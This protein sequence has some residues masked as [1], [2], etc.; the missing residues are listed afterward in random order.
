MKTITLIRHAKSSWEFNLPDYER[1]ITPNGKINT[2]KV[3][4][5]YLPFFDPTTVIW[6]SSAT[7]TKQTAS[8]FLKTINSTDEPVVYKKELYT[9]DYS[10]FLQTIQSI[11][12]AIHKII[13]FG[14]NNALTDFINHHSNTNIENLPTSAL[15]TIEFQA[16]TWNTIERGN[17]INRFFPKDLPL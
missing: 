1:P 3:A 6:C 9:F 13:I 11:P 7:R 14:H 16:Q 15:V 4:T 8:V 17:V 10:S 5:A 2:Q 12:D